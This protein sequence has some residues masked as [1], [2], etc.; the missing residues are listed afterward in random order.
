VATSHQDRSLRV[1][2]GAA[3]RARHAASTTVGVLGSSVTLAGAPKGLVVEGAKQFSA[4]VG[5]VMTGREVEVTRSVVDDAAGWARATPS[6]SETAD[7]ATTHHS[8]SDRRTARRHR[9]GTR[10]ESTPSAYAGPAP[11]R[12]RIG[13]RSA[14]GDRR[15]KATVPG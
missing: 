12:W 10:P 6:D 9:P 8:H 4:V 14:D 1:E 13:L 7:P 11:A 15:S 3:C 5:V 2:N